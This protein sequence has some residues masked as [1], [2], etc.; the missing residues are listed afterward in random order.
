[1]LPS[2]P[3]AFLGIWPNLKQAR[4]CKPTAAAFEQ[5]TFISSR[6]D[7]QYRVKFCQAGKRLL[8]QDSFP[9]MRPAQSTHAE[10]GLKTF[11]SQGTKGLSPHRY[12]RGVAAVPWPEQACSQGVMIHH[13][14]HETGELEHRSSTWQSCPL[15]WRN[16]VSLSSSKVRIQSESSRGLPSTLLDTEGSLVFEWVGGALGP[17]PV[18][19]SPFVT[20][21]LKQAIKQMLGPS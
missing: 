17:W 16:K 10:A 15:L 6:E 20:A 9:Q 4:A 3:R 7:K 21:H 8:F 5:G 2:T 19:L 12:L 13:D 18:S 14:T 1:M 11:M